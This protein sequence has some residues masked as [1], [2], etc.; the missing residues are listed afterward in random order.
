MAVSKIQ[1]IKENTKQLD[2]L[3]VEDSKVFHKMYQK[4]LG[5][6]FDSYT[7]AMDGLEGLKIYGENPKKYDIIISDHQMPRMDGLEMI[8][9]IKGINPDAHVIF[10]TGTSEIEI[11]TEVSH[12]SIDAII[13]KPVNKLQL[14]SK[15]DAIA[16]KI[17]E[18]RH[19]QLYVEQLESI[20]QAIWNFKDKMRKTIKPLEGMSNAKSIYF[21]LEA[22]LNKPISLIAAKEPELVIH[23]SEDIEED[24]DVDKAMREYGKDKVVKKP[25]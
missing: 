21:E 1:E 2:I 18:K 5:E 15:I 19:M 9:Q 17:I 7:V 8:R 12:L 11:L 13:S 14:L 20:N 23:K 22:M 10:I 25:K 3:V 6:Y 16:T 4:L 24:F